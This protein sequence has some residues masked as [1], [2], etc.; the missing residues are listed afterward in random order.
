MLIEYLNKPKSKL[1]S[2]RKTQYCYIKTSNQAIPP[3]I[4]KSCKV[5]NS[6]DLNI[7]PRLST[8]FLC[9]AYNTYVLVN[10]PNF[11]WINDSK[12]RND[13]IDVILN[14][15][16]AFTDI[17]YNFTLGI[18]DFTF[19]QLLLKFNQNN[20]L[21]DNEK[22]EAM[23]YSYFMQN[24]KIPIDKQI[25]NFEYIQGKFIECFNRTLIHERLN[26]ESTFEKLNIAIKI[27]ISSLNPDYMKIRDKLP[28]LIWHAFCNK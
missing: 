1:F 9:P 26:R 10:A 5:Y 18:D 17:Q 2:N 8:T 20:W 15:E 23:V 13:N 24:Y 28:Y 3:W 27:P 4:G 22:I 14:N 7:L 21:N 11:K 19:R 6:F 12:P 25:E 16:I